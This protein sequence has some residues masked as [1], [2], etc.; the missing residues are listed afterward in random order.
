M[1]AKTYFTTAEAEKIKRK[2]PSNAVVWS[3]I[4]D[5]PE[6]EEME[7]ILTLAAAVDKLLRTEEKG[8]ADTHFVFINNP[9]AKAVSW[10][11]APDGYTI[12]LCAESGFHWARIMYQLGFAMMHCL[13]DHLCGDVDYYPV[14]WAEELICETTGLLAL[15][16]AWR[17]AYLW[18]KESALFE[19]VRHAYVQRMREKGTS[20]FMRCPDRV[21]FEQLM[22][23]ADYA[24]R[25][26]ETHELLRRLFSVKDILS[27][28]EVRKYA[29]EHEL[30]FTEY[31]QACV[32]DSGAIQYLCQLQDRGIGSVLHSGIPTRINLTCGE[33]TAE[34][35]EAYCR[36]IRGLCIKPDDFIIFDFMDADR[37]DGEQIGV[38]FFQ[39]CRD[40]VQKV[41]AEIRIDT[42][43]RRTMYQLECGDEECCQMLQSILATKEPPDLTNWKDTTDEILHQVRP[44]RVTPHMLVKKSGKKN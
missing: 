20:A 14:P 26:D 23:K 29:D 3:P 40:H 43:L 7:N 17:S 5:I 4:F 38:V 24:D 42:E 6:D 21:A 9:A 34:Q 11:R 44:I 16:E 15:R 41:R 1:K 36:L 32:P 37:K 13:I 2:F 28:A 30:L 10:E 39:V 35:V 22:K 12:H 27:L 31:W 19:S 18:K 8:F 33:P 25:I